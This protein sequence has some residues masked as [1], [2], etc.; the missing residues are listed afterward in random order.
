MS[1]S[2]VRGFFVAGT[3]TEVGKTFVSRELILFLK[4]EGLHVGG[5]K[6]VASGCELSEGLWRNEDAVILRSVSSVPLPYEWVNPISFIPP[7]SPHLAAKLENRTISLEEI[8]TAFSLIASQVRVIVVEGAGGWLSPLGSGLDVAAVAKDLGLPVILVVGIRLGCINHARLS[9][10]HI[11]ESGI[12]FAGWV[13]NC[14]QPDLLMAQETIASLAEL[15]M[16]EP[17]VTLGFE[18]ELNRKNSPSNNHW[19]R[20]E[21]LRHVLP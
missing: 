15:L 5:M 21:I 13:A 12:P 18:P 6:P 10:R 2:G 14:V 8:R 7:I 3:D 9:I 11:R 16:E 1:E 17:L 19:N 20:G 4:S